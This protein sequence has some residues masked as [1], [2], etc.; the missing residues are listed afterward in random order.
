MPRGRIIAK[1]AEIGRQTPQPGGFLPA[2]KP[3][4]LASGCLPVIPN[5]A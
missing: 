3:T 1:D 4:R 5:P 2:E